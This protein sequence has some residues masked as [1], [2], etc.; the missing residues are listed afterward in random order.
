MIMFSCAGYIMYYDYFILFLIHHIL[1]VLD[2]GLEK[3]LV[4]LQLLGALLFHAELRTEINKCKF[5]KKILTSSASRAA[6]IIALW[7]FSS[8][9]LASLV[10]SSTSLLTKL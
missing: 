1:H 10:I 8:D 2:V 4:P 7:A 5:K 9:R 6:S 3:L